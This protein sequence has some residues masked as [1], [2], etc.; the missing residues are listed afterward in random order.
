MSR[1][2]TLRA[3]DADRE[4]VAE[5]LRKA[6]AEGRL[7]TEELE[8]RLGAA[9]SALT[10][11]ELEALVAD[12]PRE[13]AQRRR[14][15][16]PIPAPAAALAVLILMPV[17]VAVVVAAAVLIAS[18]FLFWLIAA[19]VAM[20]VFGHRMPVCRGPIHR[21]H[22]RRANSYARVGARRARSYA[23]R[24]WQASDHHWWA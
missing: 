2:T 7:S 18:M 6:T 15:S 1:R 4:L 19:A 16:L 10:Y 11:G 14:Q 5:R 17:V 20:W 23:G 13:L 9:F 3:S 24:S 21:A 8:H 12:L 22:L